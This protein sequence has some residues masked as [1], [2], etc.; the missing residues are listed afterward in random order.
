MQVLKH[1]WLAVVLMCSTDLTVI[2][3]SDH[4]F[5]ALHQVL[6]PGHLTVWNRVYQRICPWADM[7]FQM[8][9][10][11]YQCEHLVKWSHD[12]PKKPNS[13]WQYT[14][15]FW[16]CVISCCLISSPVTHPACYMSIPCMYDGLIMENQHLKLAHLSSCWKKMK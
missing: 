8:P 5:T 3:S 2:G 15:L 7:S 4:R 12:H 1:C 14:V 13:E 6:S 10:Y 16:W 9:V 11:V